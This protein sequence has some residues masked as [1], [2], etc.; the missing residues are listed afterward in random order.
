MGSGLSGMLHPVQAVEHAAGQ[1]AE[2][3]AGAKADLAVLFF[4][5]HHLEAAGAMA[6][7]VRAKLN[8]SC[9]VGVSAESVLGGET[10]MEGLPG[11]SLICASLPGVRMH[12]FRVDELPVVREGTPQE[13]AALA[14]GAGFRGP[15]GSPV[16][17][18]GTL[19]F[20]DPF[21]VPANALLPRLA[22][23]QRGPLSAVGVRGASSRPAP[24][25]GGMASASGKRGGNVLLLNDQLLRSGGVGVSFSG[26]VRIDALVSQGCKPIGQNYIVT[27]AKQQMITTLG[28]REALSVMTEVLDTLDEAGRTALRGGLFLGRAINEYKERFGRDDFLIR[29]VVG[30]EKSSGSVAVADLFRVGQTVQFF[31]RDRATADEDL[32]LLLDAQK[33]HERPAGVMVFTCNGR[34]QRLF[35]RPHHDAAAF[36]RAFAAA[37][38]AEEQ[39]K[40]GESIAPALGPGRRPV[41]IAGFFAAGE[42]GPVGDGVFVHGQSVCAAIF[43][44]IEEATA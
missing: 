34:G 25:I 3:L 36:A 1:C 14:V 10:E 27:G 21:S 43:R 19:L 41:P 29:N 13:L 32:G 15:D 11:V 26:P 2:G 33:L 7:A 9:F 40:G 31:S 4:S 5:S 30:V 35:E 38:P 8:P 28:G 18:R 37:V 16:D 17:H 6:S 44:S 24:I 42:I 12:P 20:V 22:E 23:S 39:A